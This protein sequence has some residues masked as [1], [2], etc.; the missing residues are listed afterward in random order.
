MF[1]PMNSLAKATFFF[2]AALL[3]APSS[4]QEE[5]EKALKAKIRRIVKEEMAMRDTV[6]EIGRSEIR[7]GLRTAYGKATLEGLCPTLIRAELYNPDTYDTDEA[8]GGREVMTLGINLTIRPNR[9]PLY[10]ESAVDYEWM[11]RESSMNGNGDRENWDFHYWDTSEPSLHYWLWANYNYVAL[12][13]GLSVPIIGYSLK[14]A[15][16]DRKRC[17]KRHVS[18]IG[19]WSIRENEDDAKD[20]QCRLAQSIQLRATLGVSAAF[21]VSPRNLFYRS[22]NPDIGPDPQIEENLRNTLTGKS[23]IAF[24]W[25]GDLVYKG[26]SIYYRYRNGQSDVIRTEAN[27]YNMLEV[28]NSR[29]SWIVGIQASVSLVKLK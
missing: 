6:E 7:L 13:E 14:P 22:N 5:S 1:E 27:P 24:V 3:A 26:I 19:K 29:N 18:V 23:N 17:M 21:N 20:W 28:Q 2:L 9:V 4:A 15:G 8:D 11:T 16:K 10:F 12:S 25:G